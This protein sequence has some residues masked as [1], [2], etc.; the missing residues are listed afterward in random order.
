MRQ[1]TVVLQQL[2]AIEQLV[3]D[4]R[5]RL[6]ESFNGNLTALLSW[7]ETQR[8]RLQEVMESPEQLPQLRSVGLNF[9]RE[10]QGRQRVD[11]IDG[12]LPA[13]MV[14]VRKDFERRAGTLYVVLDEL[15]KAAQQEAHWLDQA[16]KATDSVEAK[17]LL[18]QAKRFE[19]EIDLKQRN[20]LQRLIDHRDLTQSRRDAD[21]QYAADVGLTHRA[22]SHL[23]NQFRLE[24]SQ[25]TEIPARF[26]TIAPA[27]RTL[28]AGHQL[29]IAQETVLQLLEME[30]WEQQSLD[31]HLDHPRQWDLVQ[32]T[33]ESASEQLRQ[34]RVT[35]EIVRELDQIRWSQP[36]REANRKITE[37]RWNRDLMVGAGHELMEIR[38]ALE[39][40]VLQTEPLMDEARRIIAEFAPTI[41]EM[42]R[43]AAEQLRE[44][45][46]ATADVADQV[47]ESDSPQ[48]TSELAQLQQQQE[49]VN[50]QIESLFDA[51]VED[52]N[53]QDLVD[54]PQR[55][56]ARDA[57]ASIAPIQP[58]A[59]EM[60]RAMNRAQQTE[61]GRE[62]AQ[63]LAQA[64]KQ[65]E[66]TAQALERVAEHFE[67]LDEGL[68]IAQSRDQ[69]RQE[70]PQGDLAQQMNQEFQQAQDLSEMLTQDADDL[71]AELEAELKTNPVMQQAL[72]EIAQNTLEDARDALEL[73]A[74]DDERIQQANERA[75]EAFLQRKRDLAAELREMGAQA[76]KLSNALVAQA[77]QSA[78]IG[79]TQDA[80]QKLNR[81]RQ[82]LQAAAALANSAREEQLLSQLA[83]LAKDTERG[84]RDATETLREAKVKANEGKDQE[85]H[86][87]EQARQTAQ[88]NAEKRDAQ[89][90]QQQTKVA[91]NE[92]QQAA[93]AKTRAEQQVKQAEQ[94]VAQANQQVVNAEEPRK[95]TG[96]RRPQAGAGTARVTAF[97]P[98]AKTPTRSNAAAESGAAARE[99]KGPSGSDRAP[100]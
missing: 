25:G 85:V 16:S 27:Y 18:A 95:P 39:E 42:A 51:L 70:G 40:V 13:R 23:L 17:Q 59:T 66:S 49:Q 63:Q 7:S 99:C 32:Q 1:E 68:D 93:N 94:R 62:Q 83:R 78:A 96:G 24:E 57:D 33:L 15:G 61:P 4:Q 82:Q 67:R 41:P 38:D 56:R 92:T 74:K 69:L 22:A 58:P 2:E 28:E 21:S 31:A 60:N 26:L 76:A 77:E 89:F 35:E 100:A 3:H 48:I 50:D 5:A 6:P 20:N 53:T 55:E 87:D 9:L 8:L 12:N 37:R 75:D 36:V 11:T 29:S 43:Q 79:K 84:L 34:A 14:E 46:D 88:A 72:S 30:R 10:L 19:A 81:V 65:Q 91:Q 71:L 73:A 64:S 98:T 47:E 44:L 97:H 86:A 52:A 90:A 80:Q 54:E 45:E